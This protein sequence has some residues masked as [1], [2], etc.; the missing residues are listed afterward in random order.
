MP[1][2][3]AGVSTREAIEMALARLLRGPRPVVVAFSGGLDSSTILAIAVHVARREGLPLPLAITLRFPDAP[4]TREGV[5]QDRVVRHIRLDDWVRIELGEE[6][7]VIGRYAAP[8]LRSHGVGW[9][10]NSHILAPLLQRARGATVLTGLDGDGLFSEWQ[11]QRASGLLARPWTMRARDI[12]H[13]ALALASTG[14]R[15]RLLRRRPLAEPLPAWLTPTAQAACR[16]RV[17]EDRATEPLKWSTRIAWYAERRYLRCAK[18]ATAAVAAAFGGEVAHPF[19]DGDFLG[20]IA[21]AGGRRGFASRPQALGELAGD[22]LPRSLLDRADKATFHG[23][24]LTERS[25]SFARGWDGSGVPIELVDTERLRDEWLRPQPD[26]R[27]AGLLQHA[28]L[29]SRNVRDYD[30]N[31]GKASI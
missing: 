24:F 20:A 25:R 12:R 7:D 27:S 6:L 15:R 9:P 13:V 4:D 11:W 16:R 1:S 21:R 18:D 28:W 30:A 8:A 31:K 19:L 22:V 14:I 23:V 2:G 5:W 29:A 3:E 10:A 17:Q 26:F